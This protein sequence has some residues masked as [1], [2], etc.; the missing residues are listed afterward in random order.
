MRAIGL[1]VSTRSDAS[2]AAAEASA[3]ALESLGGASPAAA[4]VASTGAYG[5]GAPAR[6]LVARACA[7][8][9]TA[10]FAGAALDGL[11][12]G[13]AEWTGTPA[14]AVL[15]FD[16]PGEGGGS[17]EVAL[18]DELAGHEDALADELASAFRTP[19]EPG[20]L[21]LLFTEPQA[22]D[23]AR[24]ARSLQRLPAIGIAGVAAGE[25]TG[26]SQPVWAGDE[27]VRGGVAA[28]RIASAPG[29]APRVALSQA[30]RP[31][32][33]PM[34][35]TGSTGHWISSLEHRP[36]LDVY[37]AA[38]PAPLRDDL[39]RAARTMLVAIEEGPPDRA[40]RPAAPRRRIRNV[41]GFDEARRAFSVAEAPAPGDRLALVALDPAAA[42]DELGRLEARLAGPTPA[43]ALYLNCRARAQV[44]FDHEGY[45]LGR[46]ASLVGNRPVL[47]LLSPHLY[48]RADE[49]SIV[50]LHTY[51]ALAALIDA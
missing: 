6:A 27:V 23:G 2:D 47:G 41:I 26:E 35:I 25:S 8:L 32:G 33:E 39:P 4:V 38:V 11:M 46:V 42:R 49:R 19:I 45:E 37:R 18:L 29:T 31:V 51:A 7:E 15:A 36:A 48:G 22:V 30:G 21:I 1:G 13:G 44:L 20:D 16:A 3:D 40:G 24:V 12:V 9:G 5:G 50:E 17:A 10:Q 43:G 14:V 28:L 34:R